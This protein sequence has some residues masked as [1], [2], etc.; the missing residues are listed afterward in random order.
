ML[1]NITN[2]C[3]PN[4]AF[5]CARNQINVFWSERR[6]KNM[7]KRRKIVKL[8]I[9]TSALEHEISYLSNTSIYKNNFIID[10]AVHLNVAKINYVKFLISSFKNSVFRG[11]RRTQ[12]K[13]YSSSCG[14]KALISTV[15]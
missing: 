10:V 3:N 11:S 4:E 1:A 9:A 2:M 8:I 13:L 12:V 14:E 6:I 5:I 15:S 7:L